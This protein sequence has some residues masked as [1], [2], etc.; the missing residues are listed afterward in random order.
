[1]IFAAFCNSSLRNFAMR[2]HPRKFD[3]NPYSLPKEY[4]EAI[5]L[6]CASYAQTEDFVQMTIWGILGID[7]EKGWA[8]TTHMATPLRDSVIKALSDI[9]MQDLNDIAELDAILADLK[10]AADKRN[11]IAHHLWAIDE[12]T[13]EVFRI[14]TS[15]RVR[16]SINEKPV[17][18]ADVQADAKFIYTAGLKLMKFLMAKNL[19]PALPPADRPRFDKRK[20]IKKKNGK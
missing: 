10:T 9:S 15:A 16:L 7:A 1:M 13:G 14:E 5:G 3:F 12:D 11:S 6:A 4:L 20:A 17:P 18:L 19:V 8:L 2:K